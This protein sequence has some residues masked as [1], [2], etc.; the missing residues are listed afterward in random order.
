MS[1]PI[2]FS[3][4]LYMSNSKCR[5]KKLN[6]NLHFL[7]CFVFCSSGGIL[8]AFLQIFFCFITCVESQCFV[9]C[10]SVFS[11]CPV[12]LFIRNPLFWLELK[13][14]IL[15][16]CFFL[17][18]LSFF[19]AFTLSSIFIILSWCSTIVLWFIDTI[20]WLKRKKNWRLKPLIYHLL[21][22]LLS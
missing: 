6:L 14:L 15:D 10:L 16:V 3:N 21:Y 7:I 19:K 13:F 8:T 1:Y 9:L 5:P 20:D 4:E 17:F 2:T 18:F 12:L 22:Y 11:L